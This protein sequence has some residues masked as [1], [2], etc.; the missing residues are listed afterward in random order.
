MRLDDIFRRRTA[1]KMW[2]DTSVEVVL[3]RFQFSQKN[4]RLEFSTN[5]FHLMPVGFSFSASY[6]WKHCLH[7]HE[8]LL[9]SSSSSFINF[10]S[11]INFDSVLAN[12]KTLVLW[13][14]IL[15]SRHENES[16]WK[17]GFRYHNKQWYSVRLRNSSYT[18]CWKA[19]K[20]L[21]R[22]SVVLFL[23]PPRLIYGV[24][25]LSLGT[26]NSVFVL[27]DRCVESIIRNSRS[28]V[29][30]AAISLPLLFQLFEYIN[31]S[32]QNLIDSEECELI[33]AF[34]LE[35]IWFINHLRLCADNSPTISLNGK[36]FIR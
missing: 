10:V 16:I 21:F 24:Y 12:F 32:M 4:N 19:V 20:V 3:G 34:R 23:S 18:C 2:H 17:R 11:S 22:N 36:Q 14:L 30:I 26:F 27:L 28:F 13:K 6:L 1:W 29:W 5:V 33:S 25:Y 7:S 31:N 35:V 9:R 8:S 15:L